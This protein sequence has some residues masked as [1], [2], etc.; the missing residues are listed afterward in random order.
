MPWPWRI[1][2][3][4]KIGMKKKIIVLSLQHSAVCAPHPGDGVV[5]GDPGAPRICPIGATKLHEL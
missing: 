2:S 1:S 3:S 5:Q 4:I